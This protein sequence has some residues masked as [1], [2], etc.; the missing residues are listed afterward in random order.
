[1][2][3]LIFFYITILIVFVFLQNFFVML[4]PFS[5]FFSIASI[6]ALAQTLPEKR[7]LILIG[8]LGFFFDMI[9]TDGFGFYLPIFVLIGF[10]FR[11]LTQKILNLDKKSFWGMIIVVFLGVFFLSLLF[12]AL[13]SDVFSFKKDL[14]SLLFTSFFSVFLFFLFRQILIFIQEKSIVFY[15]SNTKKHI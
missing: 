13:T 11:F 2:F 15:K 4:T 5:I 10:A 3:F 1:M 14:V 8:I 9:F 12:Y 6:F 7:Y